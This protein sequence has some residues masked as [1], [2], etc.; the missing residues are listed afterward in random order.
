MSVLHAESRFPSR[1]QPVSLADPLSDAPGAPEPLPTTLRWLR[2]LLE[3][4]EVD[5]L[6]A[7]VILG[8]LALAVP[9][10]VGIAVLIRGAWRLWR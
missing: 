3:A 9:W 8:I 5:L 4:L 10:A 1:R 6:R 2:D 7:L